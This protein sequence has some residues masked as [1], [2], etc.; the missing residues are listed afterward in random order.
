MMGRLYRTT[1]RPDARGQRIRLLAQ[2][3]CAQVVDVHPWSNSGER[4]VLLAGL[5]C[6][7]SDARAFCKFYIEFGF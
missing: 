2:E 4:K 7:L 6:A 5:R 3:I 1:W